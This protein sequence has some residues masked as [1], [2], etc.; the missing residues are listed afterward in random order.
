VADA[1]STTHAR[2]IIRTSGHVADACTAWSQEKSVTDGVARLDHLQAILECDG[3]A[4]ERTNR[5]TLRTG[6]AVDSSTG[7]SNQPG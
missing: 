1:S 3:F 5:Y 7:I 6:P 4:C 2:P